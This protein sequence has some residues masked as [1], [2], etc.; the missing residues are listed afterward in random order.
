MTAVQEKILKAA[1]AAIVV[2]MLF[3]PFVAPI[4]VGTMQ[5]IG[6]GFLLSW[7]E[8]GMVHVELL[9]A[10]WFAI[11]IATRIM[12]VL[13]RPSTPTNLAGSLC[14]AINRYA[15]VKIETARIQA[16]ATI[17]AAEITSKRQ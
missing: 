16:D 13:S 2:T 11:G 12:W 7:P 14:L 1:L 9:L 5:G 6:F 10:E 15:D 4:G 8:R 3:P 17:R